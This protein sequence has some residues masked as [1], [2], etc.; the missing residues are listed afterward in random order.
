MKRNEI[1]YLFLTITID[2]LVA[3]VV[4]GLITEI[5]VW[6]VLGIYDILFF[7]SRLFFYSIISGLI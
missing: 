5:D 6:L 7:I 2:F 4:V 1:N 3:V